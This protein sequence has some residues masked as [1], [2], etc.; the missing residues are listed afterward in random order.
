M[1]QT[2]DDFEICVTGTRNKPYDGL[3]DQYVKFLDEVN[4]ERAKIGLSEIYK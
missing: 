3:D 2:T 4:A 1:T